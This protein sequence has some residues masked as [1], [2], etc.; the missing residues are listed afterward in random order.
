MPFRGRP[1]SKTIETTGTLRPF[2]LNK[3]MYRWDV[4]KERLNEARE[5]LEW[6]GLI[7]SSEA[8]PLQMD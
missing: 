2:A 3:K 4:P 7:L 6:S 1:L 8:E 5:E